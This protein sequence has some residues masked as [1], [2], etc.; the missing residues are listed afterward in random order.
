M[1]I[2]KVFDFIIQ[3]VWAGGGM[4]SGRIAFFLY[5][6]FFLG[7]SWIDFV[8]GLQIQIYLDTNS[9]FNYIK[10]SSLLV[11][12]ERDKWQRHCWGYHYVCKP[13]YSLMQ[14]DLNNLIN[15]SKKCFLLMSKKNYDI[16]FVF[17]NELRSFFFGLFTQIS[18]FFL[19]SLQ[20]YFSNLNNYFKNQKFGLIP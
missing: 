6:W 10:K 19:F 8:R 13:K 1:F 16:K 15:E 11:Y 9:C 3:D 2:L 17:R 18:I 7:K 12:F 20:T 5:I 14:S 4:F